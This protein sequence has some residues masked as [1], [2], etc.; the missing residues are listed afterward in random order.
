MNQKLTAA[1]A[2]SAYTATKALRIVT[3][4]FFIIITLLLLAV[5][6]LAYY[7]SAW[8]WIFAAPLIVLVALFLLLR[9]VLRRIIRAI[10]RHPFTRTQREALDKFSGKLARL[11]EAR[12]TPLPVLAFLT[13]RDVTLR[14]DTTTINQVMDDSTTL[15]S[16]F[17]DLQQLFGERG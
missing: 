6:A 5:W 2:L 11:A 4:V 15:K 12:A 8:W 13:V 9:F 16:D 17:T 7:F 10:Y 1:R 14:R 3:I